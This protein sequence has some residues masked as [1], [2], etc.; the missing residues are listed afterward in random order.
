LFSCGQ[1][2]QPKPKGFQRYNLPTPKHETIT[3]SNYYLFEKNKLA[4][5][6]LNKELNWL[7]LS[8]KK[9]GAEILI[10]FK[11]INTP[12]DLLLYINESYKLINKHK[13]RASSI[14]ETNIKTVNGKHAV[15]IDIKGEVPSPFQFITTD[16]SKNF[17]RAALYFERPIKGDSI[18]PVV[19]Y[20]KKDM[21]H[22]LNT[23]QWNE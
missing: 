17:L 22:I 14:L 23:L 18:S 11:Q 8:Y 2:Y 13:V 9:Q 6:D 3:V 16:S 10:T 15:L 20:L 19:D 12:N 4:K 21:I 5:L 7:N 1:N